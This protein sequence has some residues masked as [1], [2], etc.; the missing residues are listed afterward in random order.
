MDVSSWFFDGWTALARTFV[1]GTASYVLLIVVLRTSGKRTLSK[2]NA[3]DFVVTVAMG[4]AL[5]TMLLSKDTAVAQGAVAFVTLV[6]L[7]FVVAWLSSRSPRVDDLVKSM[8]RL[9][10]YEGRVLHD[11]LRAERVTEE[12]IET[13]VRQAGIARLEDAHAVVLESS[14]N[15][16]CIRRIAAPATALGQLRP[17]EASS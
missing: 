3:F 1:I 12:E 11:A 17:A 15:M 8:P 7:Q 14:G 16:T 5:A 13:A 9:L 10:L 4:S 2:F 6:G